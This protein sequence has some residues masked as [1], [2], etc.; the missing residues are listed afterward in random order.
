MPLKT[1]IVPP[2]GQVTDEQQMCLEWNR[3][4][5][6]KELE[7]DCILP[8]LRRDGIFD[9][10]DEE[11]VL[12]KQ[13]RS[14]QNDI[15]LDIIE[16]R[17]SRGFDAFLSALEETNHKRAAQRLRGSM[18]QVRRDSVTQLTE[19]VLE[20]DNESEVSSTSSHE[21]EILQLREIIQ[22]LREENSQLVEKA[23]LLEQAEE[24]ISTLEE[25][26]DEL[27]DEN[28]A[29]KRTLKEMREEIDEVKQNAQIEKRSF[30]T[31]LR[32]LQTDREMDKKAFERNVVRMNSMFSKLQGQL[33]DVE[34]KL[35]NKMDR[36]QSRLESSENLNVSGRRPQ[37]PTRELVLYREKSSRAGPRDGKGAGK[38]GKGPKKP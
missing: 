21:N 35:E 19:H 12:S 4:L 18:L 27:Y 20:V 28:A 23:D 36:N 26:I 31:K 14:E 25:Q 1:E 5:L 6:L 17:T 13:V 11:K 33:S 30:E 29:L 34:S 8:L 7:S 38:F 3:T 16:N 2:R 32:N 37:F 15:L 22:Q 24:K 9:A 10:A